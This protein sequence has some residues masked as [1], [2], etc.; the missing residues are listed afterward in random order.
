MQ[1]KNLHH[2][3]LQVVRKICAQMQTLHKKTGREES[4]RASSGLEARSARKL[5]AS[6]SAPITYLAVV[7]SVTYASLHLA[8]PAVRGA[9]VPD[10]PLPPT[11]ESSRPFP[12]S[13]EGAAPDD[14]RVG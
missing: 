12:F 5:F 14:V 11:P 3:A 2:H 6:T 8:M 1:K 13:S 7:T 10:A 9:G 4:T